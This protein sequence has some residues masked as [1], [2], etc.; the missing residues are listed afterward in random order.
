MS[1]KNASATRCPGCGAEFECGMQA[2][3]ERC[4]CEDFP[5][6][7][8]PEGDACYCPRCLELRARSARDPRSAPAP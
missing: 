3:R 4:W 7:P 2:G 1:A 5:P 6:L 8:N